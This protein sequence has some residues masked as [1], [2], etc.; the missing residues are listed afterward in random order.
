LL[1]G[2]E[3]Q[4]VAQA[5]LKPVLKAIGDNAAPDALL[6]MLAEL[7]PEMDSN[8]LQERLARA[9]FVAKVWGRLNA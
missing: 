8:D 1:A 5:L 6:A 3:L 7:Y 9:M 2:S 4:G